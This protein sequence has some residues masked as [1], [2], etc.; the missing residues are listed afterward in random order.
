MAKTNKEI[1]VLKEIGEIFTFTAE[2]CDC[3]KNKGD[4]MALMPK[5]VAAVEGI[6]EIKD[7]IKETPELITTCAVGAAEI[8]NV[9]VK[10]EE[11]AE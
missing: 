8:A 1:V 9:F 11:K 3:I 7:E 5:F 4:Y 10:K 6:T 2:L